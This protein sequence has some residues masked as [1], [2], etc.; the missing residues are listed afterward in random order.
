MK[1]SIYTQYDP[2]HRQ[3]QFPDARLRGADSLHSGRYGLRHLL[4]LVAHRKGSLLTLWDS[5]A[6]QGIPL[7][8]PLYQTAAGGDFLRR[9][10][11]GCGVVKL[12]GSETKTVLIIIDHLIRACHSSDD[13]AIVGN[14][15]KANE[16][17]VMQRR[18]LKT[19]RRKRDDK[20]L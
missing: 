11:G 1:R 4:G 17:L 15:K 14:L 3:L 19:R 12:I 16:R 6:N 9:G 10:N 7:T 18:G 8:L 20:I 2:Q 5:D 13:E